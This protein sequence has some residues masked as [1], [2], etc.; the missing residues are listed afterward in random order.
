MI[1]SRLYTLQRTLGTRGVLVSSLV[2]LKYSLKLY[3]V[4]SAVRTN[5]FS[6]QQ[7]GYKN[8]G[9][10]RKVTPW[11]SVLFG[12]FLFL[13]CFGSFVDWRWLR[14]IYLNY[15]GQLVEKDAQEG[16]NTKAVQHSV[17]NS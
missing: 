13:A 7:R 3:G 4:Q 15:T 11:S 12:T 5:G 2:P 14:M 10:K 6:Q 17:K 1:L 9:H 16:G 8:F